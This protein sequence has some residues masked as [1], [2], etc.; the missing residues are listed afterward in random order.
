VVDLILGRL[1]VEEDEFSSVD[2]WL[3]SSGVAQVLSDEVFSAALTLP[4]VTP[5][6]L[7]GPVFGVDEFVA[8]RAEEILLALGGSVLFVCLFMSFVTPL[9]AAGPVAIAAF[10]CL[11]PHTVALETDW[12][13]LVAKVCGTLFVILEAVSAQGF[14]FKHARYGCDGM[15]MLAVFVQTYLV[16]ACLRPGV[17]HIVPQLLVY[18]DDLDV[19][20]IFKLVE[21][22]YVNLTVRW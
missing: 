8:P 14:V 5:V 16:V 15:K 18:Y 3:C 4:F 11:L 19:E 1:K 12:A 21:F 17:G 13:L 10:H 9:T 22:S 6:L 7:S 20:I 2:L